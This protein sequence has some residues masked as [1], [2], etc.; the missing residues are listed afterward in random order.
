MCSTLT[1]GQ[2]PGGVIGDTMENPIFIVL[3]ALC[4]AIFFVVMQATQAR[5]RLRRRDHRERENERLRSLGT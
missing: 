4:V 1:R 5:S 3:L 2:E